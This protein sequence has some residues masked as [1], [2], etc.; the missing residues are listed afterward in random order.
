MYVFGIALNSTK[1]AWNHDFVETL[2]RKFTKSRWLGV[3]LP[4]SLEI[5]TCDV[6]F[7]FHTVNKNR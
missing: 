7:Q 4:Y 2:K 1:S 6:R 3:I 5:Q